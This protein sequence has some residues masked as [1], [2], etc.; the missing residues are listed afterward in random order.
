MLVFT[1]EDTAG[2]LRGFRATAR[3]TQKQL[4]DKSGVSEASI[5]GYENEENVMSLEAAV[6]LSNAL[7]VMPN[8]L[9]TVVPD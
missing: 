3:L 2:K 5:K 9:V 8:D 6:K 7:G 1:K 4:A